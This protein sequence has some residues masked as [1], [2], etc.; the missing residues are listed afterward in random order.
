MNTRNAWIAAISLSA[1]QITL[2]PLSLAGDLYV[3]VP[4]PSPKAEHAPPPRDGY[5]WGTGHWAWSGKSYYWVDG[6]WVVQRRHMHWVAVT[7]QEGGGK[8]NIVPANWGADPAT[9]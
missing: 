5:V 1:A 8:R 9:T 2:T 6:G 4:P 3:D 7:W